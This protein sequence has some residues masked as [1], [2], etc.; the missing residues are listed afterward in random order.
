[1]NGP[2]QR[3]HLSI[4]AKLKTAPKEAKRTFVISVWPNEWGGY[5]CSLDKA[6]KCI[7]LHDGTRITSGKDGTHWLDAYCNATIQPTNDPRDREQNKRDNVR[8]KDEDSL[9]NALASEDDASGFK[10]DDIPF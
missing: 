3:P 4:G 5:R 9:A 2:K 10:D 7:E 8:A 6:V 1:M